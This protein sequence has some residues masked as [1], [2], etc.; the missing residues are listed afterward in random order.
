MDNFVKL[1]CPSCGSTLKVTSDVDRFACAH[2]GSEWIVKRGG[3]VVSLAPVTEGLK[4]V[5]TGVDKT[6]AELAIRRLR[7]DLQ[8]VN[9]QIGDLN[10]EMSYH[11]QKVKDKLI[12]EKNNLWLGFGYITA[13][14]FIFLLYLVLNLFVRTE[15]PILGAGIAGIVLGV[16]LAMLLSMILSW[17]LV[18]PKQ[19]SIDQKIAQIGKQG[20][21]FTE[22]I[23]KLNE[24]KTQIEHEIARHQRIVEQ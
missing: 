18:L 8:V 15:M 1:S 5:Q 20:D 3:G 2:C 11:Q 12:G 19:R 10:R 16:S 7:E 22:D 4:R 17:L 21:V 6:A 24:K 13:L 23:V 14:L 9:I